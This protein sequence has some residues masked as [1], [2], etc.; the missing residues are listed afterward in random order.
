MK[1]KNNPIFVYSNGGYAREFLRL[2]RDVDAD[3][4]IQIIDD[5]PDGETVSYEAALNMKG[6][7]PAGMIIG[8]AAG[9]LRKAKYDAAM[10]DGFAPRNVVAATAIVGDNI[11][12]GD[13]HILSDFTIL[14]AD[15]RIGIG[16]HCNIYSYIAHD[17]EIGDFVTLAPRV[18]V[19]GRV[20]IG[21]GAYVGTGATILPGKSDRP[22][23]IGEGATIG[24]HALVTKD[25]EAGTTVVGIP[26]RPV[27]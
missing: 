23:R 21:N 10:R 13:G 15:A 27:G 9:A 26:A 25:V 11:S 14:T 19:N 8:F 1:S 16:F 24:A 22:I 5:A 18:S 7:E 17:C 6:S 4:T 3:E 12:I 2:I 20:V